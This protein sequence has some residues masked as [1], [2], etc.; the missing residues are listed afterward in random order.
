MKKVL[1][2]W[3]SVILASGAIL[4]WSQETEKSIAISKDTIPVSGLSPK[5]YCG[6]FSYPVRFNPLIP[7]EAKS[8]TSPPVPEVLGVYIHVVKKD[9]GSGLDTNLDSVM[10]KFEY[11]REVYPDHGIC[12]FLAGIGEIHNSDLDTQYFELEES[13]LMPYLKPGLFNIFIHDYLASSPGG[14]TSGGWAYGIPNPYFSWWEASVIDGNARSVVAHETGH[15]LGLFH[16]HE[17]VGGSEEENVDRTG[18]CKNCVTKGDLLC[19]TEA[20]PRLDLPGNMTGCTYTGNSLDN[21]GDP[22]MPDPTNIMS[23][24]S[25]LCQTHFSNGQ[26]SRMLNMVYNE[27]FLYD[28]IMPLNIVFPSNLSFLF[29]NGEWFWLAENYV[30]T[31]S[32]SLVCSQTAKVTFGAGGE[33]TIGPGTTFA[34]STGFVS[35]I[36]QDVCD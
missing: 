3:L 11:M 4:A 36:V 5:G 16:T 31:E 12:F 25:G 15:C 1:R 8:R 21:C 2:L 35:V 27:T 29:D 30:H 26:G 22:Y 14:S 33:V 23:Y 17:G 10:V 6:D 18:N 7:P 34:P 24:A 32:P 19:D 13:E 9:D 20:D 28:I